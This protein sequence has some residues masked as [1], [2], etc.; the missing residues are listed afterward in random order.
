MLNSFLRKSKW[1]GFSTRLSGT[2]VPVAASSS[3][4]IEQLPCRTE[5]VKRI[6]KLRDGWATY[7][8]LEGSPKYG[9]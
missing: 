6:I 2:P 7:V 8:P 3:F 9:K 5:V 1:H 4:R